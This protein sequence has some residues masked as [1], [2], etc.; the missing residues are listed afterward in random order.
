VP[1][2]S[3]LGW[4]V[5]ASLGM[6]SLFWGGPGGGNGLGKCGEQ[7]GS[8]QG[9]RN[10][11]D[12]STQQ[13]D[14]QGKCLGMTAPTPGHRDVGRAPKGVQDLVLFISGR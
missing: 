7:E 4:L 2:E 10:T 3:N 6:I 9:R 11:S 1:E 8:V 5:S 13:S 14:L 12:P